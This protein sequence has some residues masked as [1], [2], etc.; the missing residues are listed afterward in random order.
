MPAGVCSLSVELRSVYI[1][2]IE[3]SV[4]GLWIFWINTTTVQRKIL[5]GGNIDKILAIC[6]NQYCRMVTQNT[7]LTQTYQFPDCEFVILNT[8]NI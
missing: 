4:S 6:Q 2:F 1:L 5:M 3:S 7:Q 8:T